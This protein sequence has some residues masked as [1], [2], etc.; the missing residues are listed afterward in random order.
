MRRGNV[1][2]PSL[3]QAR[4]GA[5]YH[6]TAGFNFRVFVAWA[7][8]IALVIPGVSGALR[9]GSI[10]IAAV[11]LYNLGFFLST[12]VAALLY[13]VSCRIWPVPIYPPELQPKDETWEAVRYSEGFF[14]ED[15]VIPEYLRER[16]LDGQQLHITVNKEAP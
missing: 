6:Y 9:P 13:Y 10:G 5:I 14:P 1:H 16:V 11:R 8:A 7:V 3:Y 12:T 15:E 4:P 2:I